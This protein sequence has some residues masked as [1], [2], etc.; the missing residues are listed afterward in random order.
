MGNS[1]SSAASNRPPPSQAQQALLLAAQGQSTVAAAASTST[2]TQT[3]SPARVRTPSISPGPGNPHRSLRSKK[4]SLELPDLASLS[5]TPAAAPYGAASVAGRA[6]APQTKT[7]SIPIP[8][9]PQAHNPFNHYQ[10]ANDLEPVQRTTIILPSTTDM[11]RDLAAAAMHYPQPPSTHQPFPSPFPSARRGHRDE[12]QER[13]RQERQE[14]Q[15]RQDRLDREKQ[16]RQDRIARDQYQRDHPQQKSYRSQQQTGAPRGRQQPPSAQHQAQVQRIQELYDR[17]LEPPAPPSSPAEP[18]HAQ[19]PSRRQEVVRSSIPI[20]LGKKTKPPPPVEEV[21]NT[22]VEEPILEAVPI[23]I[24]WKGGGLEVILARAGD[25]DWKGRQPMQR[26]SPESNVWSVTVDLLPGTHHVR[27]LVDGIWRVADDLPAA[28]DDQGSLANYVAVPLATTAAAAAAAASAATTPGALTPVI[29]PAPPPPALNLP[30]PPLKHLVPGHS[31]W[32]AESSADGDDD[33]RPRKID[34]K[35]HPYASPAAVAYIQATWTDVLP[36]ELI[37][38]AKEEEAYLNASAGQYD[39]HGSTRVTGF[40]PAPNIPPAPG[41]PRHLDKLILNSKVG[42]QKAA[43]SSGGSNAGGSS[44][45][46]GSKKDAAALG[47]V[48][49]G[50]A[51]GKRERRD[52]ERDREERRDRERGERATRS[53]RGNLPPAPPPSETGDD[54]YYEYPRPRRRARTCPRSC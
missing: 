38:A 16:E 2:N 48:G 42:E 13:E 32:S 9:S 27:F 25:D 39:G 22:L 4:R 28:V 49:S 44:P 14:R 53:R 40:V 45:R 6:Q 19:R 37:E 35:N 51:G 12:R 26:E 43:A 46:R 17:S 30:P 29:A 54:D 18:S 20:L 11:R 3:S 52:R 5:L 8:V 10:H 50:Q 21:K 15:D 33:D 23:K 24:T 7:A 41:L 34:I 1:A 36:P 31:F 47:G